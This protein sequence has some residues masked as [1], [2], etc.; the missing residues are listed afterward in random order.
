MECSRCHTECRPFGRHRNGLRRYRCK[1]CKKTYTEPHRPRTETHPLGDMRIPME[2]A[3]LALQLLVE[4]SSV[5]TTERITG[6]HRDNDP[7]A[8]GTRW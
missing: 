6:L 7:A 4:G 2:K 5:R 3:A 1:S 8:P